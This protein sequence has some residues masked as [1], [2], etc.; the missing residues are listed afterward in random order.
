MKSLSYLLLL[1]A[2]LLINPSLLLS[3]SVFNIAHDL[4]WPTNHFEDMIVDNDTLVCYG[5]T[6][7]N[8]DSVW[9]Q[10]LLLS[11][12]DSSGN[13]VMSKIINDPYGDFFSI[14]KTWGKISKVSDGGYVM[15]SA[16]LFRDGA[17]LIKVNHN[18]ELEFMTEYRD[19][20]NLS[21]FNYKKPIELADGFLL[22]GSIQ[23]PN[24]EMDPF[25]RRVDEQGN[26]LWFKYFGDYNIYDSFND[27]A[28]INDSLVCFLWSENIWR[29]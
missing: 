15:T 18:L 7:N 26:T 28:Q 12:F 17:V 20:I 16:P 29:Q 25:V 3:Q 1:L 9:V 27:A 23:R 11:K 14:D 2:L 4:G 22:F 6:S 8:I 5:I 19:T 21:H 13:H 10:G 24:Y